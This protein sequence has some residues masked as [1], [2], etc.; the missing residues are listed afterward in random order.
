MSASAK[1]KKDNSLLK[2][3]VLYGILAETE[4]RDSKKRSAVNEL[5][6][7]VKSEKKKK[8]Y[9]FCR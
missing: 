9:M 3:A 7:Y 8:C 2:H 6:L 4:A 1:T 5:R